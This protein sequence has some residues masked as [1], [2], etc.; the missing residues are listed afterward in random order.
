MS[1][2]ALVIVI[3]CH[4]AGKLGGISKPKPKPATKVKATETKAG[5]EAA[6]RATHITNAVSNAKA[7]DT[8]NKQ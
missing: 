1:S 3:V 7:T 5:A 8:R 2:F 6:P 4:G